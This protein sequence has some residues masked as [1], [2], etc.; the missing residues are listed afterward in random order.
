MTLPYFFYTKDTKPIEAKRLFTGH[1][2]SGQL[3]K[4]RS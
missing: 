2:I 3:G 1:L 4:G